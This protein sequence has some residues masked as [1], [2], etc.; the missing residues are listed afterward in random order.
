MSS[1]KEFIRFSLDVSEPPVAPPCQ[2]G[3][4]T[5]LKEYTVYGT[6]TPTGQ[7]YQ[8]VAL[9]WMPHEGCTYLRLFQKVNGANLVVPISGDAPQSGTLTFNIV[10]KPGQYLPILAATNDVNVAPFKLVVAGTQ[11]EFAFCMSAQSG[12]IVA[13]KVEMRSNAQSTTT[14]AIS[15]VL[16]AGFV[17]D[18]RFN[19][20]QSLSYPWAPTP[21]VFDAAQIVQGAVNKTKDTALNIPIQD[22]IVALLGDAIMPTLV[23]IDRRCIESDLADAAITFPFGVGPEG[24]LDPPISGL[25]LS[26]FKGAW[27]SPYADF[28]FV[29]TGTSHSFP[30]PYLNRAT[31]FAVLVGPAGILSQGNTASIAGGNVGTSSTPP[32]GIGIT[33][34]AVPHFS[35]T[36]STYSIIPA[37]NEAVSDALDDAAS[38]Y[39]TLVAEANTALQTIASELTTQSALLPGF[40]TC[41]NTNFNMNPGGTLALLASTDPNAK[42]IFVCQTLNIGGTSSVTMTGNGRLDNVYFCVGTGMLTNGSANQGCLVIGGASGTGAGGPTALF[43]NFIAQNGC[44]VYATLDSFTGRLIVLGPLGLTL[45]GATIV[46][47][48]Q[49]PSTTVPLAACKNYVVSRIPLDETPV[50]DVTVAATFA[51][52][53]HAP[54]ASLQCTHVYMQVDPLTGIPVATVEHDT[55]PIG[56]YALGGFQQYENATVKL[57]VAPR[58]VGSL[59]NR[60]GLWI[61][62]LLSIVS[63]SSTRD[64]LITK[65]AL[66]VKRN[67]ASQTGVVMKADGV[68]SGQQVNVS[69]RLWIEYLPGQ[70]T[71]PFVSPPHQCCAADALFV[72]KRLQNSP[73]PMFRR[74]WTTPA[75]I[76]M[77]HDLDKSLSLA[78]LSKVPSLANNK[79]LLAA[80]KK[81]DEE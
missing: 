18:T 48:S 69:G 7:A 45:N 8:D 12:R 52:Y 80:V 35:F 21:L 73:I 25:E 4:T 11:N 22:G 75:Y 47:S 28:N 66:Y 13:A 49:P 31:L 46:T 2:V 33:G 65:V 54:S 10:L 36:T 59:V 23:P 56:E 29:Q 64:A 34:T 3:V 20:Q 44:T 24:L 57:R 50:F 53:F 17:V 41:A 14:S 19:G 79:N 63:N 40:Y 37:S 43:G 67:Y 55:V 16:T 60:S 61:G 32:T 72:L 76:R 30:N 5:A 58:K 38:A 70:Q 15:G 71:V 9:V 62:T 27:F 6:F 77:V 1:G 78:E 42:W 51:G 68:A 74:I 39:N 81:L 26:G